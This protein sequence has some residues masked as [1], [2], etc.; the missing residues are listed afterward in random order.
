MTCGKE[1][2]PLDQVEPNFGG[3]EE[4][5][6]KKKEREEEKRRERILFLSRFPKDLTTGVR[7][8]KRQ[9]RSSRR[10]LRVKTGIEEF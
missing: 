1:D 2:I 10:E 3:G 4:I 6:R 9:S 5:G 8:S 7:R